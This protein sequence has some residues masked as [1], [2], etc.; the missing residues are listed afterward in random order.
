MLKIFNLSTGELLRELNISVKARA[1]W[2]LKTSPDGQLVAAG[3]R[4]R[5][6]ILIWELK[7]LLG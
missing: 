2:C 7:K 5:K 4:G 6:Q 3:G 1:P